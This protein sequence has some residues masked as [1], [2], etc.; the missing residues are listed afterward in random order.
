MLKHNA[1]VQDKKV[2]KPHKKRKYAPGH[3]S[4]TTMEIPG[5]LYVLIFSYL[6]M[7]GL[8]MA[9]KDYKFNLGIFGSPWNGFDN[10]TYLF[11][12]NTMG[13]LIR[14]TVGYNLAFQLLGI[15][16]Q[17][18]AA[19]LLL[20][21]TSRKW[22]VKISQ[23]AMLLPYFMSWIVL[24]YLSH[25]LLSNNGVIN[26][27]LTSLGMDT[28]SFYTEP[29]YWPAI[30]ILFETW[31]GLGYGTLVYYGT[32]LGI[33]PTLYEAAEIDGCGYFKKHR[34][35]TL[36]MI[37]KTVCILTILNMGKIFHSDFSLFMYVPKDSGSLYSV[38]DVLD[39]YINRSLRLG[40]SMGQSTAI[41]LM[42]S[43]VGLITV[44]TVNKIV[45]KFDEDSAL[46]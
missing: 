3:W 33:D 11:K 24:S 9:F 26:H 18:T 17:V 30:L 41:S 27:I 38:T 15:A 23:S 28:I 46:F 8:I 13:T 45:S 39:L 34:Y 29:K 43:V 7:V 22:V 35:I 19:I 12:S 5:I 37:G 42:Q 44:L 32:M 40:G 31:K 4:L 36:P 20:G 10:F 6:P 1:R 16:T 21:L 2:I 14:N 25:A